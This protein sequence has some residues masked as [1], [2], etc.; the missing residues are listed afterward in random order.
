VLLRSLEHICRGH[1]PTPKLDEDPSGRASGHTLM[2]TSIA[3]QTASNAVYNAADRSCPLLRRGTRSD[4]PRDDISWQA[5]GLT[6]QSLYGLASSFTD[7][8]VELTPV[9]AW[10]DLA[11]RYPLDLILRPDVLAELKRELA[12][13]VK[14][15]HFGAQ[16]ERMAYESVVGRVLRQ[17]MGLASEP[18]LEWEQMQ[19]QIKQQ[20]EQQQQQGLVML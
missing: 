14:C 2:A 3:L 18:E 5:T 1:F 17:A 6:L 20:G 9:Q 10:F 8:D 4:L 7:A 13:V 16:L 11:S 15:P 19:P 12:P